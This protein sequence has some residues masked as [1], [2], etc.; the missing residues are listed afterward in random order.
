MFKPIL[1]LLIILHESTAVYRV[2]KY[3]NR[4]EVR[5]SASDDALDIEAAEIIFREK[6]GLRGGDN[7]FLKKP[8]S[9]PSVKP[10]LQDGSTEPKMPFGTEQLQNKPSESPGT[11]PTAEELEEL[12]DFEDSAKTTTTT[13]G[14]TTEESLDSSVPGEVVDV[15]ATTTEGTWTAPPIHEAK[16]PLGPHSKMV[17]FDYQVDPDFPQV[18]PRARGLV[19]IPDGWNLDKTVDENFRRG[20]IEGDFARLRRRL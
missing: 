13:E 17:P 2:R 11:M 18:A 7:A 20:Y 10:G 9:E 8:F 14:T 19:G 1:V 4:P 16:I 12:E 6:E 3:I 15:I 5:R